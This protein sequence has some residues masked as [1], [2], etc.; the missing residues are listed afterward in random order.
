MERTSVR[1]KNVWLKQLCSQT[2]LDFATAFW[3]WKIFGTFEKQA[4]GLERGANFSKTSEA[5]WA[6]KAMFSS[7]LVKIESCISLKLLFI[8]RIC[9]WQGSVIRFLEILLWLFGWATSPGIF[10]ERAPGSLHSEWSSLIM[11]PQCLLAPFIICSLLSIIHLVEGGCDCSSYPLFVK[12]QV[13]IV[14]FTLW[15]IWE[16]QL[17]PCVT[18]NAIWME[19]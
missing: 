13:R 12:Q 1:I 9:E 11:K 3:V 14:Y 19:G 10:E 5:F 6:R 18:D 7:C 2:I 16:K 4:S 15:N 17:V 8:L